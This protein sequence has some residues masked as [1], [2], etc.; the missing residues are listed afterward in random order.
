MHYESSRGTDTEASD[1]CKKDGN[2]VELGERKAMGKKGARTDIEDVK[3][4]IESGASYD[5][6][7]DTHFDTASRINR[8]IKQRMQARDTARER[9]SL[10]EAFENASL[11]PWQ[12]SLLDVVEET[13]HPRRIHWIWENTGGAGKSWMATYLGA[14][15][16]AT[17][18]EYGKKAD[19]AYIYAPK[20]VVFDL[21]RTAEPGEG[22]ANI[23]DH[24]Y[25]L[26]E[27]LKNGRLTTTKYDSKTIYF[28][29]PHVIFFANFSPDMTKWSE[30]RYKIMRVDP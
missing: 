2:F 6:I 21:S 15:K 30:D 11:R 5:E 7:C 24:L 3:E 17:V 10:L 29:S 1:Y 18:M 9:S 12:Q 4:A 27:S 20:I 25:A 19:L 8:F 13:P 28:P 14:A 16:E 22:K 23:L 26:A